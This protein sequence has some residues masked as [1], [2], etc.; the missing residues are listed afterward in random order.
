MNGPSLIL[1]H[2]KAGD[3]IKSLPALRALKARF[4]HIELHILVSPHNSS[5]FEYEPGLHAH[6]L[7]PHWENLKPEVLRDHLANQGMPRAFSRVV[8]LLCDAF[9]QNDRLLMLFPA[10]EKF[11]V[12]LWDQSLQSEIT[13]IP[14]PQGTPAGSDEC[15][16]IAWILSQA[17]CVDLPNVSLPTSGAPVLSEQDRREADTL[18]GQKKGVWIGFCPF[19]GLKNR[20]HPATSWERFLQQ[21]SRTPQ[22]EKIFLF[23][24]PSDCSALEQLQRQCSEPQ[25]VQLCFPSS[26]RTLGAYLRRLDGVV[27]VDS[28]PL[29][30]ARTLGLPVLGILSGGD[31]RRWFA[32]LGA[33]ERLLRRGLFNRFPMGWE[34]TWAFRRW[35]RQLAPNSQDLPILAV[36]D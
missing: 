24:A 29:H 21:V 28:G 13:P 32:S 9:E 7:P 33:H 22:L 36:N 30:L 26:F 35:L 3:A 8:S 14:L 12:S 1:R 25:R 20:S 17:F 10:T 4:P 19:A 11:A 23:G 34:M 5:L 6:R 2:D 31:V 18:M 16:N 27:A 15:E